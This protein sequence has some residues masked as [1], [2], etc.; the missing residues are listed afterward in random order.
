MDSI[1]YPGDLK[2]GVALLS[3]LLL[4]PFSAWP[5]LNSGQLCFPDLITGPSPEGVH[6]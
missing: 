4:R 5:E 6:P 3:S 1:Q 2:A